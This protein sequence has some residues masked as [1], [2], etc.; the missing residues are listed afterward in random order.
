MA[1]KFF[2]DAEGWSKEEIR[3]HQLRRLKEQVAYLNNSSPHYRRLF[4]ENGI[5]P[6]MFKSLGD[7]KMV[8]FTDKY[9]MGESQDR[10]PPFGEFLCVP[11]REIVRFFRTS[12]TTATSASSRRLLSLR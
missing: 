1:R 12:G 2:N 4:K 10:F 11:E 5:A 3:E 7:L 6:E 9:I 8:P